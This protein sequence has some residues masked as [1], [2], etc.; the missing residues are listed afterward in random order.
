[1]RTG[2]SP[3]DTFSQALAAEVFIKRNEGIEEEENDSA[4]GGNELINND[5]SDYKRVDDSSK[6]QSEVALAWEAF[7]QTNGMKSNCLIA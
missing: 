1:M 2:F 6:I 4:E 5:E 3:S 7:N